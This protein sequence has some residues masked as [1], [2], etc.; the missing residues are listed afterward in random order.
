MSAG[1]AFLFGV[2]VTI[3][4]IVGG[5]Y[6]FVAAGGVSMDTAAAPLPFEERIAH[7]ALDANL[8]AAATQTSP[9]AADE[10][11]LVAAAAAYR[12]HCAVC[13]GLPTQ[14]SEFAR[15]MFPKPPQLLADEMVTDDAEGVTY[16][17]VTHGIRLSGMPGFQS[18]LSETVRWQVTLLVAHADKLPAAVRAA[19]HP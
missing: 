12:Q 10:A 18:G 8:K 11:N 9:I 2:I 1:R 4:V 19:L 5:A 13:H 15:T 6:L 16:W 7:M 17:K 3:L 14:A